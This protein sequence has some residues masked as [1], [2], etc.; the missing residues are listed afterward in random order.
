MCEM[1]EQKVAVRCS[2]CG[3]ELGKHADKHAGGGVLA[4]AADKTRQTKRSRG[5]MRFGGGDSLVLKMVG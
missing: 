1:E 5:E 2:L 3:D 4:P